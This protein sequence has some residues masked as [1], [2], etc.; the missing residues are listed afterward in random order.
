MKELGEN[1]TLKGFKTCPRPHRKKTLRFFLAVWLQSL[2]LYYY[3]KFPHKWLI[4]LSLFLLIRKNAPAPT[5][6]SNIAF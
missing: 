2:S 6:V 5:I 3:S 1:E 4:N